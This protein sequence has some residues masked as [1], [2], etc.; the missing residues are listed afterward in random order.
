MEPRHVAVIGGSAGALGPVRQLGAALPAG[1][2]GSVLVTLHVSTRARGELPWLLSHSGPLPAEYAKEGE[3]LQP[4]QV[5]VAPPGRHLLVP[6]GVVELS[7]GPM[8][9]HFR[10]A[11]DA[12]FASAARW[13]G[14]R[15][16]AVVLSGLLDDGAVGAALVAQAGGLVVVQDPEE[17]DYPSMPRA[18]LAAVPGA[19]VAP[20][21][22][23]S[24]MVAG[25][26]GEAGLAAW[27]QSLVA[28]QADAAEA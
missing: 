5:Y 23:L 24:E 3:R 20:A 14:D 12:T 27:P 16:V 26:L 17:A 7:N 15:V 25:V 4:G 2:P 13:F 1:L 11:V 21:K 8:V 28:A 10:P 6:G 22:Q 9:N 19:I 18:A